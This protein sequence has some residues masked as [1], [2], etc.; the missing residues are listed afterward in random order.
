MFRKKKRVVDTE[1]ERL[2]LTMGGTEQSGGQNGAERGA[3][4]V[5]QTGRLVDLMEL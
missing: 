3:G 4:T 2:L 5:N 1:R